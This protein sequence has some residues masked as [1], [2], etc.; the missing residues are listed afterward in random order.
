MEIR[1]VGIVGCGLMGSGIAE[2][3]ARRKYSVVVRE[4]ND[5]FLRQG[6]ARLEASTE[7]AV[8]GNKMSEEERAATLLRIKGTVKLEDLAPC[9]FV[10]EAVSEKLDLKKDVFER[11]GHITRPE[12]ILASNT[13]SLPIVEMAA[14]TNKPD[15]VLGL[16]FFSPVPVMTLLEMVRS[17]LTTEETYQTAR[18]FGESLGKTVI[19]AKDAPG[20]VVNALLVPYQLDAIRFY[21]NGFATAEDIDTGIRLGLRHPMGPLELGDFVGLDIILDI[22]DSMFEETKDQRYAAPALLRRMVAAGYLGQ[23]SG[24]GFYNY[25]RR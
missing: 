13:S 8:K 3:V 11:L 6:L 2:V 19:V 15:R 4:V 10:I 16:H 23:K 1:T 5:D 12:V 9:D 24:K 18:A 21:E 14:M 22:A 17:F 25:P 20:F 7:R